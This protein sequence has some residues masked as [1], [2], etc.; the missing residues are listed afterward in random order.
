MSEIIPTPQKDRT[1][2]ISLYDGTR[3][4]AAHVLNINPETITYDSPSRTLVHRTEGGI[5]ADDYGLGITTLSLS[6]ITGWHAK[7]DIDGKYRDGF[8]AYKR[9]YK[10]IYLQFKKLSEEAKKSGKVAKGFKVNGAHIKI[11]DE[12]NDKT[13]RCIFGKRGYTLN[14]SKTRPLLFQYDMDLVIIWDADWEDTDRPKEYSTTLSEEQTAALTNRLD[15]TKQTIAQLQ[16]QQKPFLSRHPKFAAFVNKLDSLTTMAQNVVTSA[17]KKISTANNVVGMV[18]A[19]I[20]AIADTMERMGSLIYKAQSFVGNLEAQTVGQVNRI[21]EEYN[22]I[23]CAV[24]ALSFS[25]FMPNIK[26][27][28]GNMGCSSTLGVGSSKYSTLSN[29]FSTIYGDGNDRLQNSVSLT[30]QAQAAVLVQANADLALEDPADYGFDPEEILNTLVAG[31]IL[32]TDLDFTSELS[33]IDATESNFM[34]VES[35]DTVDTIVDKSLEEW[36]YEVLGDESLWQEIAVYNK[37]RY[38]FF[39]DDP[40]DQFGPEIKSL[41]LASPVIPTTDTITLVSVDGIGPGYRLWFDDGVTTTERFVESV[42]TLTNEVVVTEDITTAMATTISISLYNNPDYINGRVLQTG[43]KLLIPRLGL[44]STSIIDREKSTTDVEQLFGI[45]MGLS[46][47]GFLTVTDTGDIETVSGVGNLLQALQNR[48][49]TPI[50][51]FKNEPEYG[52][53]AFERIGRTQNEATRRATTSDLEEAVLRDYRVT[54]AQVD[55]Y[56]VD[57]DTAEV[58]MNVDV[59]GQSQSVSKTFQVRGV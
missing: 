19:R 15:K 5:Y 22:A 18:G 23:R 52:N 59:V 9:I 37:L 35:V 49:D 12:L 44:A 11:V 10:D 47:N 1:F 26:L 14:R 28:D 38:P 21:I 56:V 58:T 13:I 46:K 27:M 30:E 29:T 33:N 53:P 25:D 17:N 39:S 42:D 24:G 2:N 8:Q 6:G 7:R 31:S 41:T 40:L 36:A 55:Q 32:E 43:Q 54:G 50:K 16:A 34:R 57:G 48:L 4:V 51:S 45:D 3:L 20:G